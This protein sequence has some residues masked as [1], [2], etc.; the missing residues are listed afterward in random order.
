MDEDDYTVSWDILKD[1]KVFMSL[2]N[3]TSECKARKIILAL[4]EDDIDEN[5]TQDVREADRINAMEI[6]FG[7]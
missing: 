2:P 6:R 4:F 1:G 5:S 7:A 3:N